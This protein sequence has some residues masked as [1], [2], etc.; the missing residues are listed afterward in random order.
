MKRADI[1]S[2]MID[3]YHGDL[4][5]VNHFI[6]VHSFAAMIGKMEGLDDETQDILETAAIVHDIACP[7]CREKYGNASG[8]HQEEE[9]GPLLLEFLAE[10]E[11]PDHVL[12][13]VAYLVTHHHTYANV[14]GLDYQILLEADFL[15]NAGES[16]ASAKSIE[17]FRSRVFKTGTGLH[18]LDTI[19]GGTP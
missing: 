15:V 2:K 13:R 12:Q 10:F 6:K 8:K 11:L 4:H 18:F 3:F 19:Y 5:D 7:L 1:A 16:E 14:D 17:E 9:S